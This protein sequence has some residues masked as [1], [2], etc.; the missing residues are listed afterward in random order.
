MLQW[1]VFI[2]FWKHFDKQFR[3][4]FINIRWKCFK[5]VFKTFQKKSK[6]F[7]NVLEMFF[8]KCFFTLPINPLKNVLKKVRATWD[9]INTL[10]VNKSESCIRPCHFSAVLHFL[11]NNWKVLN[12][13][14]CRRILLTILKQY[15]KR[16]PSS[17]I[18]W[19]NLKFSHSFNEFTL[20]RC[21]L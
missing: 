19:N 4:I 1:N 7:K 16:T 12:S 8:S 21:L 9:S 6:H 13:H 2:T 11:I 20:T 5:N 10:I 3:K 18:P 15:I 14:V 17:L